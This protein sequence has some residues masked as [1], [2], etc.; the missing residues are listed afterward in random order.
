[1]SA[2][3]PARATAAAVRRAAGGLLA[4]GTVGDAPLRRHGRVGQ[5]L[6][7]SDRQGAFHSWLVPVTVR[8]RLAA[9]F[10]FLG[11]GE[12]MRFSAFPSARPDYAGCPAAADWLDP[13]RARQW[14]A[15]E[16]GPGETM[17]EPFMSFDRTPERLVWAVPLADGRGGSRLVLVAAGQVLSPSRGDQIGGP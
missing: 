8:D 9:L 4:G 7:V 17:G 10:Q 2:A 15:A 5:P 12:L 1:M 11:S 14:A 3:S 13:Q 16:A 6:P